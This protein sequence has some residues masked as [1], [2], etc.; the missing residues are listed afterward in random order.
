MTEIWLERKEV[1]KLLGI[2]QPAIS[3][4]IRKGKFVVKEAYGKGGTRYLIALSSLPAEAQIRW[5]KE[6]K[7]K[8]RALSGVVKALHPEARQAFARIIAEGEEQREEYYMVGGRNV[9]KKAYAV[10]EYLLD[11][12]YK[13]AERLAEELGVNP[14]T[15]YQ[16]G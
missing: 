10:K 14:S 2:S 5:I 9:D 1:E 4:A 3:K 6:N 8:A 13:T 15:I 12:R 7:D 16:L 11:P